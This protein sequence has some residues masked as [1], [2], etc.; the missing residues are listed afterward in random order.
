[1]NDINEGWISVYRAIRK[2]WIF[3]KGR[4]FTKFEAWLTILMEV[5]HQDETVNIGNAVL[6][7]NRGEK[8]YSLDTWAKIFNWNKSKVRRFF[9]LLEACSMIVLKPEQKTTR[10][11]VCN[12]DS[13]QNDRNANE[14]EVKRKRHQLNNE[15]NENNKREVKT[16]RFTPPSLLEIQSYFSESIKEKGLTLNPETEAVKF[17]AHYGSINWMVGKNKMANWKKSVT[18]WI[19]R[20]NTGGN[21]KTKIEIKTPKEWT[22]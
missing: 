3:P 18:G 15:N 21:P 8:L 10:I 16:D 11:K 19:A 17:D 1:M 4:P 9:K 7:C 20:S 6:C 5:N 22:R 14:T 12:Y 13:Y 2:H